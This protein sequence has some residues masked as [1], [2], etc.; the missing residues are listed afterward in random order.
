MQLPGAGKQMSQFDTT[1]VL[2]CQ[3]TL[4]C[5]PDIYHG[6]TL[7]QTADA[8]TPPSAVQNDHTNS[9]QRDNTRD[10]IRGM[11]EGHFEGV[12]EEEK[13]SCTTDVKLS[14]AAAAYEALAILSCKALSMHASSPSVLMCARQALS[15]ASTLVCASVRSQSWC[16]LHLASMAGVGERRS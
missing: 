16:C 7:C 3:Q 15:A 11:H 8:E 2:Q 9:I 4:A 10:I 5:R 13:K 6:C 1:T 12:F 14:T